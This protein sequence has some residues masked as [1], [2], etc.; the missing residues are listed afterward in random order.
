MYIYIY[1]YTKLCM[2]VCIYIYIYMH[3]YYNPIESANDQNVHQSN[4]IGS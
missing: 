3:T 2:Y 4:R 1:T